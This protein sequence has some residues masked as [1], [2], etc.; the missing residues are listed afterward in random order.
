[1][2]RAEDLRQQI[3]Q[4]VMDY[5]AEAFPPVKFVW[6]ETPV[7]VSGRVFDRSDLLYLVDAALDFWLTAGRFSDDFERE[8]ARFLGVRSAILCNSGSSAN[9]LAVSA[10][11]S[12]RLGERRL[13]PDDEVITVAA[14]FPTTVNPIIQNRLTPVF[15]DIELGTYNVDV[16]CLEEA[17]TPRTRAIMIAHTLGNPFELDAVLDFVKR[18]RLWFIEDNCDALGSTYQGRLTGTWGDLAT[19]SF[20][21]AHHITMGEGGC[22]LTNTPLLKTVVESFRDWGRDCWCDPGKANTCGKR[23]DWQLGDLPYG[24]DHKYIFS[25]IG[26]NLKLT[27][28]QAA[29]GVAQLAKLP[30]F[31]EIRK[32]NWTLLFEGLQPFGEFFVLPQPTPGSDPSWFGFPIT[33]RPEVRFT[34]NE[35]IRHLEEHKI[36][37]RLLFAGNLL[38]QPAYQGVKMRAVGPLTNTDVVMNQSF[39][40]G[41]YPGL[42]EPMVE[43][44]VETVA[45]FVQKLAG[46]LVR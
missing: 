23:F 7:P 41:V 24:Y 14:G 25:H 8:L 43:Y 2:Q 15:V 42:T 33:V 19:V 12:P 20:Y 32:R 10:L 31:I 45:A 22:V 26:Y 9:L 39:W 17:V 35:L 40:V 13:R 18:H 27:D 44:I 11:T 5:H 46:S 38:H 4:M 34:R 6:G 37:T 30:H 36:A 28:L 1:M 16:R 21:P 29:V 3:L